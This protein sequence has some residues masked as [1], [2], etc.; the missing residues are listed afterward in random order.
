MSL[1]TKELGRLSFSEVGEAA[2]QRPVLLIPMGT[3]EQ[4][5]PHM[6]V[7]ADNMVAEFVARNAAEK[8]NAVW[9]PG[10]NYGCSDVFRN[11]SGTISV[12]HDTL[13]ALLE[14]I[15]EGF[16]AS[17]FRRIIFVNNHGG[18]ETVV[19]RIARI[20]RKRHGILVG[21]VYP[22]SLGYA[23]MRDQ[24]EDVEKAYGH[25]GEPETSAMLAM[26]PEDT[27]ME[28]LETG[29]FHNFQGWEPAGYSKVKVEGQ[30]VP[31]TI[32][33]E[34]DDIAANGVTGDGSGGTK[35]RGEVWIER[36]VGFAIDFINQFDE[37]TKDQEWA[38]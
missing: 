7:N 2:E 27:T 6:P 9:A 24:Y 16:I 21:S 38:K 17:G 33:F 4:H 25:G 11:F 26:F 36:V 35:E 20:L 19:E 34:S 37:L 28:R 31:G 14:E 32:Y 18:N 23:L 15:C 5:G 1:R 3:L 29:T 8:T 12:G 10:V 13:T 22:W 30:S